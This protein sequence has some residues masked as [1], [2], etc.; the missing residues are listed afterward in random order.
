MCRMK[1]STQVE[2][3]RQTGQVLRRWKEGGRDMVGGTR[4]VFVVEW[5]W[6]L[7]RLAYEEAEMRTTSE[8]GRNSG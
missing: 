7:S 2:R 5:R 6:R 3:V 4:C 1:L 8:L